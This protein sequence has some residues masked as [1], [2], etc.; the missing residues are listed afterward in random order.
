VTYEAEIPSSF[1][2]DISEIELNIP[3]DE[4]FIFDEIQILS[5]EKSSKNNRTQF[6]PS[7][8]VK[9]KTYSDKDRL[10]KDLVLLKDLGFKVYS[11][12]EKSSIDKFNLY[13][14]PTLIKEDSLKI[15]E[16]LK[17]LGG[18]SPEVKVYD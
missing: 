13:V 2:E 12:Y 7:W 1:S 9:V 3:L 5:D 10:I 4:D 11:R 8:T 15:L 14:G 17:I 16:D 18:F 6:N